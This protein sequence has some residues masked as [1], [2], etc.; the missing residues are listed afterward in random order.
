MGDGNVALILDIQGVAETSGAHRISMNKDFKTHI[1][2]QTKVFNED[3]TEYL[4]FKLN[5]KGLYSIPLILVHRL[6]EFDTSEIEIS[7]VEKMVKYRGTLLPL[8]DLN[9]YLNQT[10]GTEKSLDQKIS[11][12]VLNKHNRYFGFVVNEIMDIQTS[13]SEVTPHLK[14]TKGVFGTIIVN[15]KE[16]VTVLDAL[17]I[18]DDSLGLPQ[19][20]KKIKKL[21]NTK[22]LFAEDT[23]FF[24]LQ[25]KRILETAGV[26]IDHA[27]NGQLALEKLKKAGPNYYKMI[28]SDIEMPIMD[29][30]DFAK[31]VKADSQFKN[32]PMVALTTRFNEMDQKRGQEA[33]FT[34]YLEKLKSDE[35]L[36]AIHELLGVQQ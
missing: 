12:I 35:L 18:I 9:Q 29:G 23:N 3:M 6:E 24:V 30:Y 2:T 20:T 33:G 32:I 11:V 28:L 31:T 1:M 21:L 27:E 10:L 25:V 34:K 14:D 36:D 15:E 13:R 17:G 5:Q 19:S 26:E 4:F 7:G 8:I 22:I 16:I